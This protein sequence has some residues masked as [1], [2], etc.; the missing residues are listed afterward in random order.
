MEV[1]AVLF[2]IGGVLAR[3][4]EKYMMKDIAEKHG[5]DYSELM[6]IRKKWW[7][8]YAL[9]KISEKAYWEGFLKEAGINSP[10]TEFLK[11]PYKYMVEVEGTIGIAKRLKKTCKLV[12]ISDHSREWGE[13]CVRRFGLDRVFDSIIFSYKV[14]SLKPEARIFK[15]AI[16]AAHAKPEEI[17]FID[18]KKENTDAAEMLGMKAILFTDAEDLEKRLLN[19]GLLK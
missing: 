16:K 13:E 12:I 4:I 8:L 7:R 19:M 6:S 5:K 9:D 10:K 14:K 18:N 1:R 17:L 2:D 3:D 11:L 15:A